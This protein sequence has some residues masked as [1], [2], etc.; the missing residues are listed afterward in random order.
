MEWLA[1]F[2]VLMVRVAVVTPALVAN[3]PVPIELAPSKKVT[4]PL[5]K[6]T[7]ALPGAFTGTVAVKVTDRPETEGVAEGTTAVEVSALLTTWL[8]APEGE[9]LQV[10]SEAEVA[11]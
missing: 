1:L 9:P 4:V 5:G 3:V 8:R 2:S 6:A 10:A 7:A 11:L